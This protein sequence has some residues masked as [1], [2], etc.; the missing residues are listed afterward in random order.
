MRG[1]SRQGAA[2]LV[3]YAGGLRF[4]PG[5]GRNCMSEHVLVVEDDGKIASILV[6]YLE[7]SGYQTSHVQRGDGV[8]AMVRANR[9]DLILL[10]LALP[11]L[12]GLEICTRIRGF[13]TIPIVMLTARVDE[14]DRLLGL[15]LGA[16][17]YI[18]KPFSPREVVARG[19]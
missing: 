4:R 6:D 19:K 5:M 17:D 13:S 9:F 12:N 10:D 18:C 7:N 3:G 2:N 1:P 8:E 11:G 16:D 15:E 14:I